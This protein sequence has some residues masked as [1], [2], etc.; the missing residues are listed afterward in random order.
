MA[1]RVLR[2][3][4]G[5]DATSAETLPSEVEQNY[6][7]G[8]GLA[9]HLLTHELSPDVA[10]KSA[11]N[12]LVLSAGLLAGIGDLYD[13]GFVAS[14]RSPLTGT[15]AHSWGQGGF[16]TALRRTGFDALVLKG[17]CP[18]WSYLLIDGE[19]ASLHSAA[20]L[21]GLDTVETA[22]RVRQ[23][24]GDDYQVLAIGPAGET[25]VA[26]ASIV[27]QGRFAAEPA[28]TGVVLGY[29]RLKAIAVRGAAA[30]SCADLPR[31]KK[32][33]AQIRARILASPLA[34]QLRQHGSLYYLDRAHEHGALSGRNGQDGTVA[35]FQAI[36]RDAAFARAR[37]Q[38][39]GPPARLL[40][41]HSDYI[42]RGGQ[43]FPRPDLETVA[44]FGTR[45]GVTNLDALI[46]ASDR[47]LKMGLD[48]V[49]TSAALGFLIECQQRELSKPYTMKWGDVET[50]L[51]ALG[52]LGQI[53]EKRDVLSLGVGE[54]QEIYY[55]SEVFA[56]QVKGMAMP[57]L[58]PRA[59]PELALCLVTA[60]IGGDYRYALPFEEL[61]ET[62]PAWLPDEGAGPHSLKNKA[63][64]LIWHERFAAACDAVGFDRQ[65]ALLAYAATPAEVAE[66]YGAMSGRSLG[67]AE[68]AR[69]GERIVTQE[70]LFALERGYNPSDELPR[71]W[72]AT[73]LP[74]GP[75]AH[76]LPPL[77]MLLN[78]YY[79]RHGW[80]HTGTPTQARLHELGLS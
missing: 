43:T 16:G 54:M 40:P 55:G 58:D 10:P 73:P 20:A 59:L 34:E 80:D 33:L 28:G 45:C 74:S 2:V 31:L 60:P 67:T 32:T 23:M 9:V 79:R 7:G 5:D 70:R 62:P 64:R 78:D 68:L 66:L 53:Q 44:G 12:L 76:L 26:Y 36:S 50:M 47:C 27:A 75:S 52:R 42:A 4:L 18:A 39:V 71:R 13:P 6:L 51:T 8:R 63:A 3:M 29:K 35:H 30:L 1:L 25:G 22:R 48:I 77:R 19:R 38:P 46:A 49:A 65:L 56:P 17:Q 61:L 72:A 14:T 24:H 69:I 37:Q 57:A 21:A 41:L 15:I 11:D